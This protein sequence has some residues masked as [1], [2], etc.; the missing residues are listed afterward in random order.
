MT[1]FLDLEELN[2]HCSPTRASRTDA[3]S[4]KPV[5]RGAFP[6]TIPIKGPRDVQISN[7]KL[8]VI[9][10]PISQTTKGRAN[11][12][13]LHR[14]CQSHLPLLSGSSVQNFSKPILCNQVQETHNDPDEANKS[15]ISFRPMIFF[16]RLSRLRPNPPESLDVQTIS[17]ETLAP[18]APVGTPFH[19][20]LLHICSK[21]FKHLLGSKNIE[22]EKEIVEY[23][24][25]FSCCKWPANE[26]CRTVQEEN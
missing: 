14:D 12:L 5:S 22:A 24:T 9:P 16:Q 10:E 8:P 25:D 13:S 21:I 17:H 11:C 1:G 4:A 7:K 23:M 15:Q 19:K 6:P 3:V 20:K 2:H 18:L 26:K